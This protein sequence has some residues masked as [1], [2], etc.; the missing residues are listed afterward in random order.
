[1]SVVYEEIRVAIE[2]TSAIMC[3]ILLRFMIK[4]YE[5]TGESRYIGLPVGFGFLG[6]TYLV[7][8]LAFYIPHIFGAN[9]IYIQLIARTLAFIFMGTTYYFSKKP[10]KNSHQLWKITLTLLITAL[11]FLFLIL[12]IP[13]ITLPSYGITRNYFRVL[14]LIIILYICIHVFRSHI[15]KPDP[16]TIWIPLGYVFLALNQFS[17]LLW[18]LD[19]GIYAFFAGLIFRLVFLSV[20]LI[21]SF[22]SFYR[23]KKRYIDEEDRP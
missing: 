18:Q 15:V 10:T 7:S 13:D 14:N 5:I 11:I 1:V 3:F 19:G 17:L 4:P 23:I 9:T 8:A 16:D 12:S 2:I 22:G 6:A 21:I 20:F